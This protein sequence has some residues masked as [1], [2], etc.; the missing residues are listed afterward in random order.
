MTPAAFNR[1]EQEFGV[2]LPDW[3]RRQLLKYPFI[4]GDDALYADEAGI[5]RANQELRRDGWF[6][7]PWPREFFV[8]G[9]TGCGDYFFIVPATGDQRIFIADH[10]GGPAPA[11]DHLGEMVQAETIEQYVSETLEFIREVEKRAERRQNKKWW[12]FWI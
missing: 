6:G 3:Y 10:E 5:V 7:F 12:Q 11:I 2:T 9:D 8:I 1:I 4:K